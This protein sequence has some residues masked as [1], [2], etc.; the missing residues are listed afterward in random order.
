MPTAYQIKDQ[1]TPHYLTFQVVCCIGFF[2]KTMQSQQL[3]RITQQYTQGS[4]T[5][6]KLWAGACEYINQNGQ[7]KTLTYLSGPEGV[8]ALHIIYPNGS[9]SIRYIHKDHLGSWHTITDENGNLLQ[10]LSF[11]AWGNRRNPATW[12]AFSGKV[13][14]HLFDRGFTGHEHLYSFQLINM[15]GRIY[16]PLVSRMLSPDNF[17]QAPDFSQSFNRYS[18]VWNNPLVYTDPSGD[19]LMAPFFLMAFAADY[20]SNVI[21]GHPNPG[22]TALNNVNNT[23]SGINNCARWPIYQNSNTSVTAGLDPFGFGVSVDF[24]HQTG[25]FGFGASAGI[26]LA[27]PGGHAGGSVSYSPGDFTFMF[28]G[29]YSTGYTNML[30]KPEYMSGTRLFGGMTYHDRKNNQTF[31]AGL[32]LFKGSH[33]QSNWYGSYSKGDFSF[34]MTNDA[35]T[36]SDWYRTAAAEIGYGEMSVGFNLFTTEAPL[37]EYYKKPQKGGDSEYLS[38]IHGMNP[39]GTYSTGS[40]VYAGMYFGYRSGNRV[41]RIGI[42][43]PWVQDLLQ[44]GIHRWVVPTPYFNTNYGSPP[45]PFTQGGY[46]YPF[47]LYLF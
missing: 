25:D 44:N 45:G 39:L 34:S 36:G 35:W 14:A 18:Y 19:W 23:I 30:S 47:S 12:R 1:T 8:F 6:A 17:I 21:N 29:G 3:Q 41:S 10:E 43:A 33:P 37:S 15:N 22:S 46:Q 5:T 7:Q 11:D 13:P 9:D 32:T 27:S 31:S 2:L 28:G 26:G 40:R 20:M 4:N 38:P 24:Y 42:D 16:D